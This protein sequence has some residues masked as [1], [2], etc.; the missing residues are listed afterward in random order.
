MTGSRLPADRG[1]QLFGDSALFLAASGPEA[2]GGLGEAIRAACVPGVL[3]VVAGLDSVLVHVDPD[4]DVDVVS[5]QLVDVRVRRRLRRRRT[6]VLRVAF[7]GPDLDEVG[8]R[9]GLGVDGVRRALCSRP[10]RVAFLGFTPGFAYLRGLPGPLARVA[11]RPSPRPR[12]P[13]GSVAVGGGHAAVYPQATPGGWQLVGRTDAT[14]FDPDTPP[15]AT[16]APGDTV[17][18]EEVEPGELGPPLEPRRTLPRRAPDAAFEVRSPGALTTPQDTGRIGFAHLGV[19]RSGAADPDAYALAN[20]LVGNPPDAACLEMTAHGPD[21]LC[22]RE[23]HVAVVGRDAAVSVDGRPAPVGRVIPLAPGQRLRVGHTGRDLRAYL[24]VRGGFDTPLVLGSRSVDR[25]VGLGGEPLAVGDELG[26]GEPAGPLADH[27]V[28]GP[29]L[30]SEPS[31]RVL[32]VLPL[33]ADR[34]STLFGRPFRVDSASDRVGI[35]LEALDEGATAGVGG[36]RSSVGTTIGTVQVPPGGDPVILGPDH[37]TVGG[38]AV[39]AVVISADWGELGRCQ[40]GDLVELQ[41]VDAA[42]A[43]R[44]RQARARALAAAVAGHYPLRT[45]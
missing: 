15:Y 37:A 35:R 10:L 32:R 16:L 29:P 3:D 38:Y 30:R 33:E 19:P 12:V 6:V 40:P 2:A 28:P 26:I 45:A 13:A 5:H 21:L 18:F 9:S 20:A 39:P 42:E 8:V 25:L 4:C 22:R 36:E 34:A 17:R 27:L 23:V 14:L 11:R 44:A 41:P 43:S 7:D 1:V 24:A 31:R